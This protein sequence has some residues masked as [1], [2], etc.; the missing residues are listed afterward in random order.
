MHLH[1]YQA[2]EILQQFGIPSPPHTLVSTLPELKNLIDKQSLKEAVLKAQVHA[3]GRGKAGGVKIAKTPDEI[4]NLGKSLLKM[5]LINNQTG[6]EGMP[7]HSILVTPLIP[8][9]RELYLAVTIDRLSSQ[10]VLIASPKGE[11]RSSSLQRK[12]PPKF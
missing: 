9:K 1:E 11:W 8:I 4:L 3:G 5:R 6:P 7:V 2:K 12:H 10:A